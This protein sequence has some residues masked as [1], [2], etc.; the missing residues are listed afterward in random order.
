MRELKLGFDFKTE[1]ISMEHVSI[2]M[3]S[4]NATVEAF[5]CVQDSESLDVTNIESKEFLMPN[6]K[7]QIQPNSVLNDIILILKDNN[8]CLPNKEIE[9]MF[10]GTLQMKEL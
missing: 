2:P 6:I 3:K 9:T 7:R 5:Y 1:T 4:M 8:S 10:D